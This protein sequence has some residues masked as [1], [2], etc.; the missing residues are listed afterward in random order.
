M[1]KHK[2]QVKVCLIHSCSLFCFPHARVCAVNNLILKYNTLTVTNCG[3]SK[4]IAVL[5]L[6]VVILD[7]EILNQ[8]SSCLEGAV[9]FESKLPRSH[10][11]TANMEP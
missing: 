6:G 7:D 11:Y 10:V 8:P 4:M 1:T 3:E 2:H 5:M 9:L